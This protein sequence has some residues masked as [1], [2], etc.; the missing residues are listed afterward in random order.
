MIRV[1][2]FIAY[3]NLITKVASDNGRKQYSSGNSQFTVNHRTMFNTPVIITY[4]TNIYKL[5]YYREDNAT[6]SLTVKY[7]HDHIV[8]DINTQV[9]AW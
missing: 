1:L 2:N 7:S 9:S 8:Q 4:C 3:C 5:Y 6:V